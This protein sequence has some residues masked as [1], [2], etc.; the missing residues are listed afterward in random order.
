M[1]NQ[2]DNLDVISLYQTDHNLVLTTLFYRAGK[3]SYK[4]Y[5]YYQVTIEDDY[6]ELYRLY[7]QNIYQKNILPTK[8]IVNKAI[9]LSEL[10]L[11]FDNRV[12][13]PQT[14]AEETIMQLATDN[15][16]ESYLQMQSTA[17]RQLNNFE[18]L[19]ELQNLLHLNELPYLIE[20]IDIA[21]IN[22]EFV[23]GGVIV[24]KNG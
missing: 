23:T 2:N 12:F 20:M 14:R 9:V 7:L 5:E 10:N 17:Q 8:I 13:N 3:L 18:V 15:S 21:N 22:D 6:Q 19:Q 1:L 24:Y 4:D 16:Y 11:L